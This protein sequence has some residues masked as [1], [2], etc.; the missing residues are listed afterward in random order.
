[1]NKTLYVGL[2]VHKDTIA[3]AVAED[4][5]AGEL[6]FH[7]TIVNSADTVLRLT[8]TL[9]KGGNIPSFCFE[10]GPFGCGLHRH[11]SKLELN[12]QSLHLR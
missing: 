3:V 5:R 9:S 8:K 10:A 12:A 6:R 4:G 7:G 1:M 2:D 11:L